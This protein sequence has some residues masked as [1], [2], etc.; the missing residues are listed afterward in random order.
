MVSL[1]KSFAFL[2]FA[3]CAVRPPAAQNAASASP[4]YESAPRQMRL[5]TNSQHVRDL[6]GQAV[7]LSGNYRLDECLKSL[8]T[9]V[10]E[11]ANFAAGWGLLA[12]YATD[13]REAAAA[14]ARAQSL[15]G[16]ASP[17]EMLFLQWVGSLKRND[18]LAAI[19]NLNDL[20]HRETSDKFVLYLAGRW[21]LDQ[22]DQPQ[23]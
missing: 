1:R 6:F 5:T 16:R 14:L 13:A 18:Q 4:A 22:H 10:A 17:S 21:F 8:R 11:D 15:V 2:V 12:Y 23:R 3:L 19:A 20:V 9:A 7:L